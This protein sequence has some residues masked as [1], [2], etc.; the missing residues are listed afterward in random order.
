MG[1]FKAINALVNSVP[2]LITDDGKHTCCGFTCFQIE[3]VQNDIGVKSMY[4]IDFENM[5]GLSTEVLSCP[6]L[7]DSNFCCVIPGYNKSYNKLVLD[8]DGLGF[9]HST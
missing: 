9:F 1:D 6:F 7:T 5:N 8:K 4:N 3:S 2:P